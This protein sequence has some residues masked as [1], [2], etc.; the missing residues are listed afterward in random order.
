MIR[1]AAALALLCAALLSPAVLAAE[2]LFDI[3]GPMELHIWLTAKAGQEE[4]M[5]KTFREVFYPA[6]SARE[7][8]RSAMMVRKPGTSDYTVRLSF[9]TEELRMAWVASDAHQ[10]AWPALESHAAKVDY[11]GFAIVHPE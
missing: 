4:A 2:R 8:F 10:Q 3:D 1:N 5:E 9:D 6:V 7:G 11:A